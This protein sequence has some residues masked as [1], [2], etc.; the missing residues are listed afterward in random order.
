M[1]SNQERLSMITS[2]PATTK[3]RKEYMS[4]ACDIE[5]KLWHGKN[6]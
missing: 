3:S 5:N 1:K 2:S 4:T 6:N